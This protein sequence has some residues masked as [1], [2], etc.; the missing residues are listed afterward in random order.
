MSLHTRLPVLCSL[1]TSLLAG[2]ATAA[3]SG[4]IDVETRNRTAIEFSEV[5]IWFGDAR[6]SSGYLVPAAQATHMYYPYPITKTARVE[7]KDPA[8]KK[9]EA[10][11]NLSGVYQAGRSGVLEI[12]ITDDGVVAQM[13]PLP[14]LSR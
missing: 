6:C 9:H 13:K 1:L 8:G 12:A 7:W 10:E 4:R 3:P 2:C 14:T 5:A 11:V